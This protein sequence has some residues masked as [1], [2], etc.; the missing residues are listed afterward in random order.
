MV[1][2]SKQNTA[3]TSGPIITSDNDAINFKF[4]EE[5][6]KNVPQS[7]STTPMYDGNDVIDLDWD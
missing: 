6:L 7:G 3:T 5:K 1:D 4:N 2:N